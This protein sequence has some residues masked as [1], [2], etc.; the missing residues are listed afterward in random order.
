[1][2]EGEI[3]SHHMEVKM[4]LKIE[5]LINKILDDYHSPPHMYL[6]FYSFLNKFL[7]MVDEHTT[8]ILNNHFIF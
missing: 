2:E 5:Q 7:W 6:S 4:L 1:M 3:C 8:E